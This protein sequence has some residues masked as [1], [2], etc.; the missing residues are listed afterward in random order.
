MREEK[1]V[2][3]SSF[4]LSVM[5]CG[6]EGDTDVTPPLLPLREAREHGGPVEKLR[7]PIGVKGGG[8]D[9]GKEVGKYIGG[10][11]GGYLVPGRAALRGGDGNE[12]GRDA[13]LPPSPCRRSL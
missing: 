7:A 8:S 4:C 1:H 12:P 5:P 13:K 3:T 9:D 10:N 2:E 11:A 6:E